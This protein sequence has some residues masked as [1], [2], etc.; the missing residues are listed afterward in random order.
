M[1]P[2]ESASRLDFS[3]PRASASQQPDITFET[4]PNP[5]ALGFLIFFTCVATISGLVGLAL[6][7][8]RRR[9]RTQAVPPTLRRS[10]GFKDL[11]AYSVPTVQPKL[12]VASTS[13]SEKNTSLS[14]VPNTSSPKPDTQPNGPLQTENP[15]ER[16]A[17][18]LDYYFSDDP[19]RHSDSL[20]DNNT[21]LD[22]TNEHCS[23]FSSPVTSD[24]SSISFK[25]SDIRYAC[26]LFVK[27]EERQNEIEPKPEPQNLSEQLS[28]DG[29]EASFRCSIWS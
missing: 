19:Q 24:I 8:H 20:R 16:N 6:F 3:S 11:E 29:P 7:I 5:I 15:L 27:L 14:L 17:F 1:A 22:A 18:S 2:A 25:S 28:N 10:H 13:F 21:R 4:S 9:T 26:E 23:I 12:R